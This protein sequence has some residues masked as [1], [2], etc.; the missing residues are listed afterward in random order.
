V[1]SSSAVTTAP[2]AA[3]SRV[4]GRVVSSA[5]RPKVARPPARL[6]EFNQNGGDVL[7]RSI[8]WDPA[9]GQSWRVRRD[10]SPFHVKQPPRELVESGG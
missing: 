2:T 10:T 9:I 8:P 1:S 6:L 3:S 7:A 5:K 4:I